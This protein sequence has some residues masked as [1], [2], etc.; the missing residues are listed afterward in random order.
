MISEWN[1]KNACLIL[2]I[3]RL[4][5][6]IQRDIQKIWDLLQTVLKDPFD[7][8]DLCNLATAVESE[9]RLA[10]CL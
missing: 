8:D 10:W 7:K 9:R 3:L 6:H 2:N 5:I 4:H 1:F